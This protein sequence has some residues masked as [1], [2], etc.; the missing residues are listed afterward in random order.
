MKIL[1]FLGSHSRE[2]ALCSR[3]ADVLDQ[4]LLYV[5]EVK[6]FV[7]PALL[8]SEVVE[9][10]TAASERSLTDCSVSAKPSTTCCWIL[11]QRPMVFI[12]TAALLQNDSISS[13]AYHSRKL[14]FLRTIPH[15]V[16]AGCT[17]HHKYAKYT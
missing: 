8:M 12:R 7:A 11:E 2:A 5:R 14:L 15:C 3:L 17:F 13:S 4:A 9:S 16:A 6:Q 10:L 1:S